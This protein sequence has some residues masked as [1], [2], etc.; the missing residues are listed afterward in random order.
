MLNKKQRLT[1]PLVKE[2]FASGRSI[3]GQDVS[4]V[5]IKTKENLPSK[6]SFSISAKAVKTAVKRNAVRRR[7]YS[8][9]EKNIKLLKTSFHIVFIVKK[10]VVGDVKY[11]I[12]PVII[13][14]LK[15]IVVI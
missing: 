7:G 9:L 14:L 6:F 11:N 10:A 3:F 5:F 2:V 1:S 8:V 15:K 12:E 4:V 13:D